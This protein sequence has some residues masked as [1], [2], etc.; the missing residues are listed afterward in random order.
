[1]QMGGAVA[2]DI[3][4]A[5][6]H[7]AE[8]GAEADADAEGGASWLVWLQEALLWPFALASAFAWLLQV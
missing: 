7:E 8:P 6:I 1:M 3:E 2:I 5:E 4:E